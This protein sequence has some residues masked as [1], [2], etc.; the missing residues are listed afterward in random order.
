MKLE[1][2]LILLFCI[3]FI[4]IDFV[5]F[6]IMKLLVTALAL[7]IEAFEGFIDSINEAI[8]FKKCS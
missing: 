7:N 8:S 3:V 4:L 2:N 5:S 1:K 6:Q